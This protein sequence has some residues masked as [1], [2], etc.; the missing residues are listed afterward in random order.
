MEQT[1]VWR[2]LQGVRGRAPVDV[3]A[4]EQVLVRFSTLVAEQ[5]WIKEIDINPLIASPARQVALD[6]RVVLHPATLASSALPRPAIRP[7]PHQYEAPWT[8]RSGEEVVVR[9]IRPE[10]EP[11]MI[12][13]HGLLSERSVYMRYFH[14]LNLSQR[15]E[16]DRLTRICF[17]DYDCEMALVAVRAASEGP[18]IVAVSR[19]SKEHGTDS[20]EMAALVSD[21]FQGQGLGTEL[22][23]R[24]L[25]F[26]RDEGLARVHSTI[27][28]QNQE[29]RA[30]CERLG[31]RIDDSA[32]EDT[33]EA[34]L[35]LGAAS[36]E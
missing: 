8:L 9:P 4:L 5:P 14:A 12:R 13:F 31:F 23:R 10:D 32:D 11:M 30:V 26:A 36:R 15:T 2:A 18:E 16:H 6:A 1:R 33:V 19:L 20:A 29:M 3:A 21:R 35:V 28:R 24:L 17:I 22:Y 27:L 25:Q 7:Y 34:E